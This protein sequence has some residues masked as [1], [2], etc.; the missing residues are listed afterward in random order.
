[1]NRRRAAVVLLKEDKLL[2]IHRIT[3]TKEYF[4]F[5]GGGVESGETPEFAAIRELKEETT[6]DADLGPL[7]YHHIYDDGS[8]EFFYRCTNS[9]GEACLPA[10]AEEYARMQSGLDSYEPVWLPVLNLPETLL[11]PLEIRD[12]LID[13]LRDDFARTP[14]EATLIKSA[15]RES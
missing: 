11:Y 14:R 8:E 4:T 2:L 12:W 10:D 9:R 6:L 1:M 3:P 7:L 5:P 13:D 15:R